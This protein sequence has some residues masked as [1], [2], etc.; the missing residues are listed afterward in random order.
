MKLQKKNN[1]G[2]RDLREKLSG[3]T[4]AQS[5]VSAPA[6]PKAVPESSKPVRKSI[7]AEAPVKE[8]RKVASTVSKKK[9]V[10]YLLLFI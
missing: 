1:V 5:A 8:I 2:V 7:V 4:Y 10:C 6:K 9:K 3:L